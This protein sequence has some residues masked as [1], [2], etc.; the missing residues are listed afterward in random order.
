MYG[1]M[2]ASRQLVQVAKASR[3]GAGRRREVLTGSAVTW[4][5]KA[6]APSPRGATPSSSAVRVGARAPGARAQ[7]M[8]QLMVQLMVHLAPV[9][10]TS[11]APRASLPM[12][13]APPYLLPYRA[14]CRRLC[15]VLR[16]AGLEACMISSRRGLAGRSRRGRDGS[17]GAL[18]SCM[19]G[20]SCS[21]SGEELTASEGSSELDSRAAS[22]DLDDSD[23]D[24]RTRKTSDTSASA[25]RTRKASTT[26]SA[27]EVA[28]PA[29]SSALP[30]LAL[31]RRACR[32]LVSLTL[33]QPSGRGSCVA[34]CAA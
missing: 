34:C 30:C 20:R 5:P 18:A 10:V 21:C 26:A 32:G 24:W 6:L 7:M 11:T 8:A 9:P 31:P 23:A 1:T 13:L 27:A 33:T 4:S 3:D 16:V 25:G 2:A 14:A 29:R 28:L 17:E 22:S 19:S 15:L 12:P